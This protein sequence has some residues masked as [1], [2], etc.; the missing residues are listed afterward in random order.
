M[1][2]TLNRTS[3]LLVAFICK[4][5]NAIRSTLN[6]HF[7]FYVN[8][9][10]TER[11]MFCMIA[12]LVN[13]INCAMNDARNQSSCPKT[14]FAI[15]FNLSDVAVSISERIKYKNLNILPSTYIVLNWLQIQW[16]FF[17][18]LSKFRL[19]SYFNATHLV[20]LTYFLKWKFMQHWT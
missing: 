1:I 10:I 14:K 4:F 11:K 7:T 15:L 3:F 18:P 13:L 6:E 12:F 2:E 17:R 20:L 9:K 8:R 5:F 19:L 16:S